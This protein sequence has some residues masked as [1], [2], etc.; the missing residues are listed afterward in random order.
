MSRN[1]LVERLGKIV[2]E[3]SDLMQEADGLDLSFV[4]V[5]SFR[6]HPVGA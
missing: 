3:G 1:V 6:K 5:L 2:H 4:T